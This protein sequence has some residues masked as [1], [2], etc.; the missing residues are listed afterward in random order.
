MS[1][2]HCQLEMIW[3]PKP[4][5]NMI[6]N[7]VLS[8]LYTESTEALGIRMDPPD[9]SASGSTDMGNVSHVVPSIHPLFA[10]GT[11]AANHTR[12]FT[13]AAGMNDATDHE[14]SSWQA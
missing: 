2:F 7:P 14:P 8:R 10:I 13:E 11:K 6:T 12:A 1:W 4:Y 5:A 3:N 9:D